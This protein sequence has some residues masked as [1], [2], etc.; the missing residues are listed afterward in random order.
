LL[1]E[2][3]VQGFAVI[4]RVDEDRLIPVGGAFKPLRSAEPRPSRDP[5][6]HM[7]ARAGKVPGGVPVG[8]AEDP[9]DPADADNGL[10]MT[11]EDAE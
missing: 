4:S 1:P 7:G 9:V 11:G 3:D 2:E 5:D 10:V 8:V 6:I